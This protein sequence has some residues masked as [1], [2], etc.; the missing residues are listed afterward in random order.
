[1]DNTEGRIIYTARLWPVG[2]RCR[3]HFGRVKGTFHSMIKTTLPEVGYLIY[4]GV[5]DEPASE[6]LLR[7]RYGIATA[8]RRHQSFL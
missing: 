7:Y 4:A 1:M 6:T 2:K 3:P 5:R 8:S